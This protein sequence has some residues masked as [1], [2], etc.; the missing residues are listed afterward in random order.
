MANVL[1]VGEIMLEFSNVGNGLYQKS[2][3]GDSFNFAYY[4]LAISGDRHRID[5]LTALG[6]DDVSEQCLSFVQKHGVGISRCKRDNEHT[7]GLFTL[8][9]DARGE[10]NYGYWRGQSAAR[11]LFDFQQDLSGYD[12]VVFSGITA[13][14]LHNR[15]NLIQ[16]ALAAKRKGAKLAYDFNYR[17]L[18]WNTEEACTFAKSILPD[19]DLVK[20]SDEELGLLFPGE[21]IAT[22]SEQYP[23]AEWVLTCQTKNSEVWQNGT[24]LAKH[25]FESKNE[26]E[27]IEDSS[28]AG[29]A[30][31][32]VYLATKLNGLPPKKRLKKGHFVASQVVQVKGSIAEI[33]F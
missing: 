16:S 14:I 22:L 9:N 19:I 21:R 7:I 18:L 20:I 24:I 15:K 28:G 29:D 27:S 33:G 1:T 23:N 25:V 30:F 10:K 31:F 26:L 32:A 2:Y 13:A 8:D 3:A 6:M 17:N 4:F 12:W 11:H 5:Y